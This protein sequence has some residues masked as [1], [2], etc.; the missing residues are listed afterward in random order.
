MEQRVALCCKCL[1]RRG[2]SEETSKATTPTLTTP[3]QLPAA[4]E[5]TETTTATPPHT[6]L[7]QQQLHAGLGP[8]LGQ[9]PRAYALS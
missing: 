8:E 2:R 9:P 6:D 1:P 4:T 3:S 7:H 5:P